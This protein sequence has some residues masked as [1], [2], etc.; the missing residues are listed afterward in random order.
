LDEWG[1][2]RPLRLLDETGQPVWGVAYRTAPY[3]DGFV[4]SLC[5]YTPK[6]ITVRLVNDKNQPI[7][8]MNLFTGEQVQET[9]T[10]PP[11]E[12]VL[13]RWGSGD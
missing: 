10:L 2:S 8:A 5:N 7:R 4:A 9:L 3:G 13:L 12:P 11:L 6:P 1:I